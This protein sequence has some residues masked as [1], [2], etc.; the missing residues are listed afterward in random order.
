M[1]KQLLMLA[2]SVITL[3]GCATGAAEETASSTGESVAGVESKP[4]SGSGNAVIDQ[5]KKEMEEKQEMDLNEA[6]QGIWYNEELKM[7]YKIEGNTIESAEARMT[8]SGQELAD[9]WEMFD[10]ASTYTVKSKDQETSVIVLEATNFNDVVGQYIIAFDYAG[11]DTVTVSYFDGEDGNGATDDKWRKLGPAEDWIAA[12]DAFYAENTISNEK[13]SNGLAYYYTDGVNPQ[14]E[15]Y[16]DADYYIRDLFA[17]TPYE[18]AAAPVRSS[19][20]WVDASYEQDFIAAYESFL[21]I[22]RDPSGDGYHIIG[23]VGYGTAGKWDF[24]IYD[25]TIAEAVANVQ[26]GRASDED[27]QRYNALRDGF[28]AQY[29]YLQSVWH[30]EPIW[31]IVHADYKIDDDIINPV[32]EFKEG[33]FN[34]FIV[35]DDNSM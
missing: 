5:L 19:T 17:G 8:Q 1:Q 25:R 28:R 20:S 2:A 27:W 15:L 34:N 21:E 4:E 14:D 16:S 10:F 32:F 12:V 31:F 6:I 33:T 23:R 9:R 26:Y 7:F 11:S 3:T 30:A 29:Q 35:P 24:I 13:T 22:Q 18:G